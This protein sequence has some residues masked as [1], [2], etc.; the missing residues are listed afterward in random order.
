M[1]GGVADTSTRVR[2]VL[3]GVRDLHSHHI[4]SEG[5]VRIPRMDQ[6]KFARLLWPMELS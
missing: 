1:Y 2:A 5:V 3:P 4:C 6:D